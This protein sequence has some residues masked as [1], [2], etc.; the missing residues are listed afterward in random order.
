VTKCDQGQGIFLDFRK[1][2]AKTSIQAAVAPDVE[3]SDWKPVKKERVTFSDKAFE[4]VQKK[5][6]PETE[7]VFSKKFTVPFPDQKFHV[8]L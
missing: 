1:S 7:K 2:E 4:K 3:R 8:L 5:K 6:E